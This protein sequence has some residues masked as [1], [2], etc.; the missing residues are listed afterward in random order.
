[1]LRKQA[2]DEPSLGGKKT[3]QGDP[4]LTLQQPG[5]PLSFPARLPIGGLL[6][7]TETSEV[8]GLV[9]YAASGQSGRDLEFSPPS[10]CVLTLNGGRLAG[11]QASL[12]E[13]GS[14]AA[15]CSPGSQG[16]VR[17]LSASLTQ[18]T[19]LDCQFQG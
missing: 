9:S 16:P 7:G 14:Q 3:P 5:T 2:A 8:Q 1:M 17:A 12:G 10:L 19:A 11:V 6:G 4:L 13:A 18:A 15:P